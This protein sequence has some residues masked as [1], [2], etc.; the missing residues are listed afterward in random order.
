MT[1]A[2]LTARLGEQNYDMHR[3]HFARLLAQLC[4]VGAAVTQ[5]DAVASPVNQLALPAHTGGVDTLYELYPTDKSLL[6]V[7]ESGVEFAVHHPLD[8]CERRET[9]GPQIDMDLFLGNRALQAA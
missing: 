5:I 6:V 2:E 4:D 9:S 3:Q 7:R 1:T 8:P